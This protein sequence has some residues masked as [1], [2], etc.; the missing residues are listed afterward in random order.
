MKVKM[1]KL[2][3]KRIKEKK[4]KCY[5]AK[6]GINANDTYIHKNNHRANHKRKMY[7]TQNLEKIFFMSGFPFIY[8]KKRGGVVEK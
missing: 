7:T 6:I 4:L 2:S 1:Y 8:P 5:L 3:R